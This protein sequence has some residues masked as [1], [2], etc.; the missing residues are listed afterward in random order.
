MM[1][2]LALTIAGI[3]WARA[4]PSIDA[5]SVHTEVGRVIE[6]IRNSYRQLPSVN[7]TALAAYVESAFAEAAQ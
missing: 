1:A 2:E 4:A 3:D 6:Q 7:D 5:Y